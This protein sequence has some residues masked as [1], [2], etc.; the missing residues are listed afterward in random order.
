M[1]SKVIKNILF[2]TG[3]ALIV[4][5][6][7]I[8]VYILFRISF[9]VPSEVLT[10]HPKFLITKFDFRH[11]EQVFKSGNLWP[12]LLKS[13]IVATFTMIF[14][15]IIAAPASYAISR[16]NKK[17][18]Y[19]VILTLFFTRMFPNVGIALPISVTFLK[20][21]L[22]DTNTGLIMAHLIE[23]LP[24]IAW[25]LV[26]TFETIPID[27]EEAAAIDGAGRIKTLI[28]VVF[29]LAAP[30]LA[31]AAMFTWLNSWN[32]FTYALYLSLT[33]KTLPLQIYY[34][35]LRGGFFQQAAYST[36][37][38]IPVLIIT[39]ALQRYIRSDYLGGAIK[40]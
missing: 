37:L 36:I 32:E 2:Y 39:F 20:W 10:S 16:F 23:Q 8:P 11:W 15:L 24:F 29:P 9:A 27:L 18:K 35:V 26:S 13:L 31:V 4:L 14:A 12:P 5:F 33:T 25:I 3:I 22:L 30:G 19:A 38:T 17:I 28:K 6:M 34:Y 7:V 40:G 1:K 21:H